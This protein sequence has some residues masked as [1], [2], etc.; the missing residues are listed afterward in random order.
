VQQNKK[1][2]KKKMHPVSKTIDQRGKKWNPHPSGYIGSQFNGWKIQRYILEKAKLEGWDCLCGKITSA[3]WIQMGNRMGSPSNAGVVYEVVFPK[4]TFSAV[5]KV[6]PSSAGTEREIKIALYLSSLVEQKKTTYFPLVYSV[7]DNYKVL[8]SPRD[9]PIS[10]Y[11]TSK[12]KFKSSTG[13]NEKENKLPQREGKLSCKNN[14]IMISER[15]W[16]DL[17]QYAKFLKNSS[18]SKEEQIKIWLKILL[19]IEDAVCFLQSLGILHNDLHTGN[20]LID[21]VTHHIKL[22]DFG[23]SRMINWEDPLD[24]TWDLSQIYGEIA[25]LAIPI[26]Q[27]AASL[28]SELEGG[29]TLVGK[30]KCFYSNKGIQDVELLR[31]QK[32]AE[33]ARREQERRSRR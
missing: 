32:E 10:A 21:P 33:F 26:S 12:S 27:L 17:K 15:E 22:H 1:Q 30:T 28:G 29:E 5:A 31:K 14:V 6:M 24:A 23:E 4:Q 9:N 16:G 7:L 25:E 11:T 18:L 20:I 19:Q 3:C 13:S 2:Q 8:M